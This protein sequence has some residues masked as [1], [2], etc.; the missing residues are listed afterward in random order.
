MNEIERQEKVE[1]IK[2]LLQEVAQNGD[3]ALFMLDKQVGVVANGNPQDLAEAISAPLQSLLLQLGEK[4]IKTTTIV[5]T[6]IATNIVGALTVAYKDTRTSTEE[7]AKAMKHFDS[8]LH[9]DAILFKAC[10]IA[11]NIKAMSETP[12]EEG[13]NFF[14][15]FMK[16]FMK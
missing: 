8:C 6:T 16:K 5:A 2:K 14:T 1:Q 10:E 3:V 13:K 12:K 9:N 11:E 15:D 7:Y 4:N